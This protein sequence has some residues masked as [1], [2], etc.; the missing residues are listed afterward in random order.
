MNEKIAAPIQTCSFSWNEWTLY[1]LCKHSIEY[2]DDMLHL[3]KYA[4]YNTADYP[5]YCITQF[6]ALSLIYLVEFWQHHTSKTAEGLTGSPYH[7]CTDCTERANTDEWCD[8]V[9]MVKGSSDKYL[10][11]KYQNLWNS[12]ECNSWDLEEKFY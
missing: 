7:C 9:Q 2:L 1:K 3:P 8:T 4:V 10:R 6:N 5:E 12:A 11:A